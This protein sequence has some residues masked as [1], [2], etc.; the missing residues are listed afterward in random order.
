MKPVRNDTFG[1][2][3]VT[4][5]LKNCFEV[6]LLR[7]A[8][9]NDVERLVDILEYEQY[10]NKLALYLES[11]HVKVSV[12]TCCGSGAASATSRTARSVQ[13]HI[14]AETGCIRDVVQ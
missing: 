1:V 4:N 2:H 5:G 11:L 10:N 9:K 6:V 13:H 7:L 3:Q 8:T 14:A 12:I